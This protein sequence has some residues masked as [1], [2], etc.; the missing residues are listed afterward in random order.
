ML[1]RENRPDAGLKWD[2]LPKKKEPLT[3][4]FFVFPRDGGTNRRKHS[5]N[6]TGCRQHL[7]SLPVLLVIPPV[8]EAAT[9]VSNG[10]FD[11]REESF[12]FF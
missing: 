4:S 6:E 7:H 8:T 10:L 2:F 1:L 3:G 12:I 5:Q 9:L 11:G